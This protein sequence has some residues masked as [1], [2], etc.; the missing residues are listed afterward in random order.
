MELF[1]FRGE[2]ITDD[3]DGGIIRR[4]IT[5]G[6]GYSK[7][8]EGSSVDGSISRHIYLYADILEMYLLIRGCIF[9]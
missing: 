3:E 7:P 5:R 1:E 8:N 9:V 6:S 4:I 2:D